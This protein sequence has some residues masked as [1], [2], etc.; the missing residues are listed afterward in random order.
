MQ[1][2][3]SRSED[4]SG[5]V[6]GLETRHTQILRLCGPQV[7]VEEHLAASETKHV[8]AE[9]GQHPQSGSRSSEW[10]GNYLLRVSSFAGRWTVGKE[11]GRRQYH[12]SW[13]SARFSRT[14]RR[15]MQNCPCC[16]RW[17]LS[18]QPAHHIVC[19]TRRRECEWVGMTTQRWIWTMRV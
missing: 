13:T 12:K 11:R 15:L 17:P 9:V 19:E 14:A 7:G 2:A 18:K 16:T 5:Y 10:T 4:V 1:C 8:G 3:V 6:E